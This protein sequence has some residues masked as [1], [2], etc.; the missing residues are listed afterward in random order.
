MVRTNPNSFS[1]AWR[2]HLFSILV[3][4]GTVAGVVGLFFYRSQRFEVLGLAQGQ[5]RQIAATV[6]GRLKIVSVELFDEVRK[7]Q[8]LAT[9]DDAQLNDQIATV[10]AEIQRLM[11][12]LITT[13]DAL[14]AEAANRET[15]K[16]AAQ[17]R[18]SVD[19]ENAR[20]RILELKTVIETD[21]MTLQDFALEVKI[22]QHLLDEQAIAPYE[23]Q[24]AQS[25]HD[26]LAKTIEE[27]EHLLAQAEHDLEQAKQRRYEFAQRRLVHPSV[28]SALEVIHRAVTVQERM[29]DQ[30]LTQLLEL[31]LKSPI[32]GVV[33][34]IQA[35]ANQMALRRP[36]EN[37]LRRP[38][39]IVLAGEP[40]LVVAEATPREVIAYVSENQVNQIREGTVV[41]L[42][43]DR[44]PAQ[45][46][47]S[48]VTYIGPVVEQMPLRLWRNP[49]IP[50]WGRPFLVKVP[51]Q[52]KLTPGE[53]VG[54]R[55]L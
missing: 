7:D 18:F 40:I 41:E 36:G 5:V 29:I 8:V 24:K 39:E 9:L 15:D 30:L 22:A 37:V 23:K 44:K 34:Q 14:M 43:K 25:L 35:N 16:V 27:N 17:R 28:D 2:R 26:A 10:S 6:D 21:R 51:P 20:L 31:V 32:D 53:L 3:W 19:V 4:T 1:G 54:I 48:Q 13:Q 11:A 55:R 12:E 38:G 33:V 52:M 42:I 45:I 49:N 46:A 50:E 47:R